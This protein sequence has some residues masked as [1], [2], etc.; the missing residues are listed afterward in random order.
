MEELIKV[1]FHQSNSSFQIWRTV[2]HTRLNIA[3]ASVFFLS[4]S[5]ITRRVAWT[6]S[7]AFPENSSVPDSRT[8]MA[9]IL[10]CVVRFTLWSAAP[11]IT[12]AQN[13]CLLPH[14]IGQ[15][16]LTEHL[17]REISQCGS[18]LLPATC[19]AQLLLAHAGWVY[20]LVQQHWVQPSLLRSFTQLCLHCRSSGSFLL[21]H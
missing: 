18:G 7:T 4:T 15:F 8:L 5:A 17:F 3:K 14:A 11:W 6:I 21:T 1:V 2:L 10:C 12:H 19:V 13:A 20:A 16:C 9:E